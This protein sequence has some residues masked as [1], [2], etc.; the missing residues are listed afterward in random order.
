MAEAELEAKVK[1]LEGRL[2]DAELRNQELA[3]DRSPRTT[4]VTVNS[5]KDR[6]IANF[7]ST[8]DVDEWIQTVKLYIDSKTANEREKVNFVI[9]H[10]DEDAK[11]ELRLEIDLTRSTSSEVFQILK[12]VYSIK[13]TVFELQQQLYARDQHDN[14]SLSEYSHVL[15]KKLFSMQKKAPDMYK[16]T[17]DILKQRFAEGVSDLSLKRELKRVNRESKS[18]KFFQVRDIAISWIRDCEIKAVSESDDMVSLRHTVKLQEQKLE[19]FTNVFKNQMHVSEQTSF[20]RR[21]D[22]H[23]SHSRGRSR[24]R[25]H[26]QSHKSYSNQTDH[27]QS[28][29]SNTFTDPNHENDSKPVI[30]CHYC[31]VPNHIAPNCWKRKQDRKKEHIPQTPQTSQNPS[32]SSHSR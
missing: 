24:G 1:L 19:E 28:P 9:D 30:I 10:L 22:D 20:Q 23:R 7:T 32:N 18:L 16:D 31:N 6:K 26:Y 3:A 4:N 21:R 12:N 27:E 25:R 15:M 8:C 5:F 11:T 13:D 14:E 17:D 29:H 2:R